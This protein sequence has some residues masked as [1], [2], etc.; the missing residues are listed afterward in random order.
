MESADQAVF[1]GLSK[2]HLFAEPILSGT[3]NE[4]QSLNHYYVITNT[5]AARVNRDCDVPLM[6]YRTVSQ[7]SNL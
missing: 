5:C 4:G 7:Y 2:P 1:N 6:I 3:F